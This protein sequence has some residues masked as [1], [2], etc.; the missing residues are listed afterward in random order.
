M[1]SYMNDVSDKANLLATER[2][3]DVFDSLISLEGKRLNESENA[4]NESIQVE[5]CDDDD[6]DDDDDDE[7]REVNEYEPPT[8]EFLHAM[9]K[10]N[11]FYRFLKDLESTNSIDIHYNS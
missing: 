5:T 4:K 11:V 8:R 1:I 2:W 9:S 6:D 10:E 7:A 3:G